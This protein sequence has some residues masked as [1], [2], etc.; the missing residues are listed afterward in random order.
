M[1]KWLIAIVVSVVVCAATLW[2]LQDRYFNEEPLSEKEAMAHITGLY[3]G[4]VEHI[5]KEG[6]TYKVQLTKQGATYEVAIDANTRQITDLTLKKAAEKPKLTQEQIRNL[7]ATHT[8]GEIDDITLKETNYAVKVKGENAIT[9]LTL[10]IYTGEILS[11]T[12]E[13]LAV[14]EPNKP[15]IAISGQQAMQIALQ[16]LKG[17]VESV[18][19]E[20]SEDGGYYLI[21][22][23]TKNEEAVFQIHAVTKKIMSVEWDEDH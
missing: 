2:F 18:E 10:D 9:S 14:E 17:E 22:I 13:P 23:E 21:E 16:Q 12:T 5:E 7:V 19:Y 11:E 4:H 8:P 15:G 3:K 1:K 20:E 6:H